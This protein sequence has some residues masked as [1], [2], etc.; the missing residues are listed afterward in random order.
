MTWGAS[1]MRLPRGMTIAQIAEEY[2]N[3]WQLPSVG[4]VAE[5]G[6]ALQSLFPD[7][8]HHGDESVIQD[9]RVYVRF[10]YGDKKGTGSVESIG[11]VSNGDEDCIA[12]I[13]AVCERLDLRMVD[14]QSGEV[15]D[16]DQEPQCS[17]EEYREFRERALHKGDQSN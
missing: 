15:A 17:M 11:V 10:N 14:H 1:L 9:G 13:Q 7:A 12:V 3:D 4:S 2:G 5:I 16:F 6:D 8:K